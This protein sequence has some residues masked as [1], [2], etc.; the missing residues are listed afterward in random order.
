MKNLLNWIT[1]I[2]IIVTII[3]LIMGIKFHDSKLITFALITGVIG[4]ITYTVVEVKY[5]EK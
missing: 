3:F 1:F 5:E 4:V 2:G